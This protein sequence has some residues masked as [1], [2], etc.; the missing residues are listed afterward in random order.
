M[1]SFEPKISSKSLMRILVIATDLLALTRSAM[2]GFS[3]LM[4]EGLKQMAILLADIL[5][6]S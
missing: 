6:L 5:L 2:E 4:R 3:D 1:D